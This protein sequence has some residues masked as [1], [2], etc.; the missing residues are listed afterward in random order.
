MTWPR[1]S[2]RRGQIIGQVTADISVEGPHRE[3]GRHTVYDLGGK[4]IPIARHTDIADQMAEVIFKQ[5]AE[6]L[7]KGWW[8]A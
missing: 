2:N 4:R 5:A 3:G 6:K 7:G 8:N 1:N